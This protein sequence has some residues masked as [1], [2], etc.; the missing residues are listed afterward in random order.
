MLPEQ[1][2]HQTG[3]EY[4]AR[5][6]G[7]EPQFLVEVD[8]SDERLEEIFHHLSK[9][10]PPLRT[11]KMQ[12]CLALAAVHSAARADEGKDSFRERHAREQCVGC[13]SCGPAYWCAV[14]LPCGDKRQDSYGPGLVNLVAAVLHNSIGK[15]SALRTV[16]WPFAPVHTTGHVG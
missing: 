16:V 10:L 15:N 12:I 11:T 3:S 5:V 7:E 1:W 4:L 9:A 2:L 8:V 14:V 13:T 6:K